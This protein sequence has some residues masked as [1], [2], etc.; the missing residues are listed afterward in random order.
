MRR[1]WLMI[2]IVALILSFAI[3]FLLSRGGGHGNFLWSH[4]LGFFAMFGFIACVAI[5]VISKLIGHYWLQRKEDYYD[6]NDDDD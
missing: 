1:F 4:I 6:R 5:I 3:D 2:F